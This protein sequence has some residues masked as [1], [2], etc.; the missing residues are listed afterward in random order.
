MLFD[1]K[2]LRRLIVPLIIEQALAVTCGMADTMMISQSG[3]AA[4]SGV[5]LVDMINTL[6]INI[7]AA[8]STGGAVVVS[9][10]I[11]RKERDN[12]RDAADQLMLVTLIFSLSIMALSL[13]FKKRV[14]SLLFGS[15]D[16]DVMQ[17]ALTYFFITAMS[18]PFLAIYNSCAAIY[19][20]MGN[21]RISMRTSIVMN[22]INII[23]NSILIFGFK[24]GVAGAAIATLFSRIFAAVLMFFLI[25]KRDNYVYV[26]P[27]NIFIP[28]WQTAKRILNI[29][30]PSGAEN[31]VFQLGRIL[32]VSIIAGFG[33]TQIAA[34]AVANNLDGLGIMGGQS[35][36]LAMITVIGQCLGAGEVEQAKRYTVK[37]MKICYCI[38]LATVALL[39]ST[40]PLLLKIYN[41]SPD[42][43]KL[44]EILV[45]IHNGTAVF[46]WP[47][48]FCLPNVFR[49]AGDVRYPMT[50]SIASM[51]I[52]RIGAGYFIAS[53]LGMG[54]I[55]IWIAMIID[56]IVRSAFFVIRYKNGR[57][58]R[59]KVI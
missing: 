4:I 35:M 11:G 19:R 25:V 59:K 15:I 5:S 55:G 58:L 20:S 16:D 43:T 14:L 6:L 13:I 2:T 49:A 50:V 21:S 37:L 41:L 38:I 18:F 56:W 7:F 46:L 45:V 1:N 3:E 57:W 27:K 31:G 26:T 40:L 33:T 28:H 42:S 12:A 53:R 29:G 34:N 39:L 47:L 9:Q 8:V 48:S 22:V 32:V 23:G 24:M 52:M 30:L 44:A 17:A 54:A 36:G 51:I 10:Y